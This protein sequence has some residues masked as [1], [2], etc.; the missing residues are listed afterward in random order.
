[1]TTPV[2]RRVRPCFA[3]LF[4][5]SALAA[6][7]GCAGES[8]SPSA[9]PSVPVAQMTPPSGMPPAQMEYIK[10]QQRAA[11]KPTAR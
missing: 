3:L 10:A 2:T 9:S 7:T 6:L 1:M 11:Q 4:G 5:A 8:P